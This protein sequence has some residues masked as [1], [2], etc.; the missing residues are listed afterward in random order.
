M[1]QRK[2]KYINTHTS[3][4]AEGHWSQQYIITHN[5]MCHSTTQYSTMSQQYLKTR[6][7]TY[8]EILLKTHS[9][10]QTFLEVPD[11][12]HNT[13]QHL[14]QHLTTPNISAIYHN[15]LQLIKHHIVIYGNNSYRHSQTCHHC[16]R[17]PRLGPE[18]RQYVSSLELGCSRTAFFRSTSEALL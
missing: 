6:H 9:T 1:S 15:T 14:Q 11:T 10:S 2:K 13:L 3:A 17:A 8:S 5:T 18:S 16:V 7:S 12:T 4:L